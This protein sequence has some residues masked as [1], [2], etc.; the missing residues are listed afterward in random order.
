MTGRADPA[1]G[2]DFA[3][4]GHRLDQR[5]AEAV[6]ATERGQE[7]GVAGA[8]VSEAK[9]EADHHVAHAEPARQHVVHELLGRLAHEMLVEGEREQ[10]ADA[11]FLQDAYLGPEWRQAGRRLVGSKHLARMRLEGDHAERRPELSRPLARRLD[12]RA[13]AAVDA[14]EVADRHHPVQGGLRQ[15]PIAAVNLHGRV[16]PARRR[17]CKG[18]GVGALDPRSG[19]G[20]G[21]TT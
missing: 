8:P 19:C 6:L 4:P 11:E 7:V 3:A 15:A 12:Q 2:A 13:M 20:R 17:N 1:R 14:V 16:M 18:P 21:R 5:H 9:V 10:L